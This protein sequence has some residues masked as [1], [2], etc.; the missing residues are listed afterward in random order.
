[1]SRVYMNVHIALIA[2]LFLLAVAFEAT[3]EDRM[4]PVW[5]DFPPD[6]QSGLAN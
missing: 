3:A 1:M 5:I 2:A 6:I 4:Q